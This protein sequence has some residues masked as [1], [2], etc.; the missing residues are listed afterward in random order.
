M[1]IPIKLPKYFFI[2]SDI[3]TQI[4]YVHAATK[5]VADFETRSAYSE[6]TKYASFI[7]SLR[8]LK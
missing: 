4:Y 2:S 8:T 1:P 6:I 5:S 3:L 7:T